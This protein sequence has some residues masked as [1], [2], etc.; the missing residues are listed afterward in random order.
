MRAIGPRVIRCL[1]PACEDAEEGSPIKQACLQ[2]TLPARDNYRARIIGNGYL[3]P[4]HH[5]PPGAAS[6][7]VTCGASDDTDNATFFPV[8][9]P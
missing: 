9:L 6:N 3:T 7:D 5:R 1:V 4:M 8:I 2:I